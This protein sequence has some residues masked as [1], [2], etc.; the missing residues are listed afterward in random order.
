[1][2]DSPRCRIQ[3]A[4]SVRSAIRAQAG[5][6]CGQP[7]IQGARD[8]S[9]DDGYTDQVAIVIVNGLPPQSPDWD[10][11]VPVVLSDELVGQVSGDGAKFDH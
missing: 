6:F 5:D 8:W 10:V 3:H 4:A 7:V 9:T 2:G 11:V 1:L